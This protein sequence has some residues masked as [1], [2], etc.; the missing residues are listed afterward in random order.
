MNAR[1]F[2][3]SLQYLSVNLAGYSYPKHAVERIIP[4]E[5]KTFQNLFVLLNRS[6]SWSHDTKNEQSVHVG[7]TDRE[8]NKPDNYYNTAEVMEMLFCVPSKFW[9]P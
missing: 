5:I 6:M 7:M 3:H 1:N 4:V 2:Y 9:T 8:K